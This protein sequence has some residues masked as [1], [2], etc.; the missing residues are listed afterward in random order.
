[1][2]CANV[3]HSL[4]YKICWVTL[5]S[6]PQ[7]NFYL[8]TANLYS[9][10]DNKPPAIQLMPFCVSVSSSWINTN[11]FGCTRKKYNCYSQH[12]RKILHLDQFIIYSIL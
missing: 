3:K 9:S 1:M 5:S 8:K 2:F 6:T 12:Q 10:L 7:F 11:H 4:A